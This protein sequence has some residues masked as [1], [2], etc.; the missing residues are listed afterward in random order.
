MNGEKEKRAMIFEALGEAS[1]CWTNLDSAGAFLSDKAS[2]VGEEL[3]ARLF[4]SF[5]AEINAVRLELLDLQER[6][7]ALKRSH[8]WNIQ[9]LAEH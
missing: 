9:Q 8:D 6:Y 2:R 7:A 3:C 5:T 1:A 4:A